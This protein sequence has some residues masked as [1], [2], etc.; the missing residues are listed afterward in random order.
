MCWTDVCLLDRSD[1]RSA[2]TG[3]VPYSDFTTWCNSRD[4]PLLS[5][6]SDPDDFVVRQTCTNSPFLIVV[7]PLFN[8]AFSALLQILKDHSSLHIDF[9]LSRDKIYR[10]SDPK[11]FPTLR[12]GY[13]NMP[14]SIFY[15]LL[16]FIHDSDSLEIRSV[17]VRYKLLIKTL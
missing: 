5:D 10:F 13:Y 17:N 12:V 9:L 4:V 7:A 6:Y 1:Y 2:V 14:T 15:K 11:T 3:T 8:V 16:L